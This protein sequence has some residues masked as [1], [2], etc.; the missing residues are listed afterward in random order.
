MLSRKLLGIRL[1]LSNYSKID[2]WASWYMFNLWSI[3]KTR[4]RGKRNHESDA[5]LR[6]LRWNPTTPPKLSYARFNIKSTWP[7][8]LLSYLVAATDEHLFFYVL[9]SRVPSWSSK[10]KEKYLKP[11]TTDMDAGSTNIQEKLQQQR[12]HRPSDRQRLARQNIGLAR[13]S[14]GPWPRTSAHDQ[15]ACSMEYA[16]TNLVDPSRMKSLIADFNS[17]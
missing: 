4:T 12:S 14:D 1:N 9:F 13:H 16:R 10:K 5:I 6:R 2:R 3:Y 15:L 8:A 11:T 7:T 17:D